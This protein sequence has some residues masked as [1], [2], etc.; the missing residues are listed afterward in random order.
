MQSL[1]QANTHCIFNTSKLPLNLDSD[2]VQDKGREKEIARV[3][4]SNIMA[5]KA[6]VLFE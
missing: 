4:K 2:V 6:P 3:D 5:E 1:E